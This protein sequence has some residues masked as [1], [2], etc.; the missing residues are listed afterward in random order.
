MS[1]AGQPARVDQSLW[2]VTKFGRGHRGRLG[3]C[4]G[5]DF[6]I[7]SLAGEFVEGLIMNSADLRGLYASIGVCMRFSVVEYVLCWL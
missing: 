2:P 5:D 3:G 7:T 4:F 6:G 1:N